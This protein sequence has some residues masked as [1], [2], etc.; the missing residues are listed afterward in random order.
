MSAVCIS[1]VVE[2]VCLACVECGPRMGQKC[3]KL[4]TSEI[5]GAAHKPSLSRCYVCACVR[6][7]PAIL[8]TPCRG[9]RSV[10]Q[11]AAYTF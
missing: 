5:A 11:H 2:V 1:R 6:A 10:Q 8:R 7:R 3:R 9:V 4:H